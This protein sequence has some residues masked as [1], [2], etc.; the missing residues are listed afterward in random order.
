MADEIVVA[1]PSQ[2]GILR[3]EILRDDLKYGLCVVVKASD[4][5]VVEPIW[6]LQRVQ[7]R[8]QAVKMVLAVCAQIVRGLWQ[9]LQE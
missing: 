9:R 3:T 8:Q 7:S 6:N 5:S 2:E 4:Q 1:A